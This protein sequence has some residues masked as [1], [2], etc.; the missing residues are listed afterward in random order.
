[1]RPGRLP[2]T[3]PLEQQAR[4]KIRG[5]EVE[6]QEPREVKPQRRARMA[7]PVDRVPPQRLQPLQSIEVEGRRDGADTVIVWFD[8]ER[9]EFV[10]ASYRAG[11]QL[12]MRRLASNGLVGAVEETFEAFGIDPAMVVRTR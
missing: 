11:E 4:A 7:V 2:D 3:D 10:S 9:S 8:P 12:H 5:E 6:P 1:M